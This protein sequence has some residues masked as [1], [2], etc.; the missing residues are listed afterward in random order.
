V[1]RP[2]ADE[3]PEALEPYVAAVQGDDVVGFLGRQ[4]DGALALLGSLSPEQAAFRYAPD[5]WSVQQVVGH[6]T[7]AERIFAGRALRWAR[8]D[9]TPLHG[10]ESGRY[11]EVARALDRSLDSVVEEL[12][13][14]RSANLHL[15]ESFDA[16]VMDRGG[17]VSGA[18]LTVRA[19][20]FLIGGHAR[21]HLD[22]LRERYL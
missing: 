22:V 1:R 9:E 5:K 13:H 3:Y 18:R 2:K 21:H 19:T 6:V 10:F 12:R 17:T 7:D 14:L 15:F 20:L 8:G 16:A 4:L 11:V